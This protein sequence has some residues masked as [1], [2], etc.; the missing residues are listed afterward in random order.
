MLSVDNLSIIGILFLFTA[1]RTISAQSLPVTGHYSASVHLLHSRG[2]YSLSSQ[3]FCQLSFGTLVC[4][5]SWCG[6]DLCG[7]NRLMSDM[8]VHVAVQFAVNVTEGSGK[9]QEVWLS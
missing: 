9:H 3:M 1:P 5:V 6:I 2:P 4:G 7:T 8:V